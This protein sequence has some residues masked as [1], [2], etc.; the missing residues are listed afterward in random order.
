V[1]SMWPVDAG[2]IAVEWPCR[3]PMGMQ[4]IVQ[5]TRC[6][7]FRSFYEIAGR[8]LTKMVQPQPVN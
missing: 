5:V 1:I 4:F 3:S 2:L 6:R 7:P 8:F